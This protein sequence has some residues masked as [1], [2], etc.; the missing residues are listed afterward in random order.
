MSDPSSTIACSRCGRASRADEP[1]LPVVNLPDAW[2]GPPPVCPGCQFTEWHPRCTSLRSNS[3]HGD[4]VDLETLRRGESIVLSV[5][6]V[7]VRIATLDE[8]RELPQRALGW[9]D[10]I[11]LAVSWLDVSDPPQQWCC[12]RC[13]GTGFEGV[14]RD[15]YAEMD[16]APDS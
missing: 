1:L 5:D 11:D 15:Y 12:P 14:H 7:A 3:G 2:Q 9:C 6:G 13:G 4:R 10:Y 16:S 8:L